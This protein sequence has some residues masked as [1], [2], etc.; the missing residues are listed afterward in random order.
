[1]NVDCSSFEENIKIWHELKLQEFLKKSKK[2]V[3]L[4]KARFSQ[5]TTQF[6]QNGMFW[7]YSRLNRQT[8]RAR[9]LNS[10]F[11]AAGQEQS[12]IYN[13]KTAKSRGSKCA[14]TNT[15]FFHVHHSSNSGSLLL[16]K[17]FSWLNNKHTTWDQ[18]SEYK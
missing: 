15:N 3:S 2:C 14:A 5:Q 4:L 10:P 9:N 7:L 12:R 13:A 6:R 18:S 16:K 8:E 17:Q 11:Y 1:M